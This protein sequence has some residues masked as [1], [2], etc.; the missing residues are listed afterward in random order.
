MGESLELFNEVAQIHDEVKDLSAMLDVLVRVNGPQMREA[1][2]DAMGKD[3]VLREVF[4]MVDGVRTQGE[5]L[6]ELQRMG[7]SA[8]QATV[9]RKFELL[10]EEYGLVKYV[11]RT[12]AGKVY[13]RT[14]LVRALKIDRA[15]GKAKGRSA[16]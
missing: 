2:L 13:S 14:R 9:S 5:I 7:M 10:A 1:I 16:K 11:D 4:L 12:K 3:D 15:L 6:A 8:G